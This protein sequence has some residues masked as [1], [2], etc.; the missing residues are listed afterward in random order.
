MIT[1]FYDNLTLI[2]KRSVP[3][4]FGGFEVTYV[5]GAEFKGGITTDNSTQARVAEKEGVTALYT[6]TVNDTVPLQYA[7]IVKRK[8][9]NKYF[10]VV[11]DP[12]DMMAPSRATIKIKQAQA[13]KWTMPV[14]K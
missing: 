9:D 1:D 14:N 13:E 5:E 6:I 7:D 10:R 12:S 2:E 11:S 3:D 8:S 4:G